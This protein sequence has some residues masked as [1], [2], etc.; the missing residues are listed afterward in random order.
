MVA[1]NHFKNISILDINKIILIENESYRKPWT[2]SHFENDIKNKQ[3]INFMYKKNN[4]IIAYLFGYLI[5]DEYHLN[6]ITVKKIYRGKK[7]GK[8]L[9]NYCLDELLLRNV[10]SIQLEVS[11]LNLVAQKFYKSLDFL[12]V[13]IRKKYYSENE[14]ALL[15]N[16]EIK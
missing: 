4:E 15:Y 12:Q 2:K 1:Y 10:K 9:F 11:S 7:I 5:D 16:L 8:T 6:K 14:D 3:S 13:G